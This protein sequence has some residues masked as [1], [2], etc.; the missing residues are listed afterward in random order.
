MLNLDHPPSGRH[1]LQIPVPSP[2]PDRT[3]RALSLPTI[4]HR[5]PEFATL[6]LKV[7]EGLKQAF[8]TRHPVA[9]SP[10]SGTGAWEAA[11][12]NVLSAGDAVLMAETSHFAMLRQK[13]ALRLG[14]APKALDMLLG[15]GLD[16]VLARHRRWAAGVRGAV[17]AWGLP[18]QCV[19]PAA[20]SPVLTGVI[21]PVGVDADAMDFFAAPPKPEATPQSIAAAA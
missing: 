13:M 3:L 8:R 6:G 9:I 15:Q 21:T 19:D 5:G 7:I 2:V 4:D 16:R 17:H 18:V 1:F 20:Q 10:A 14:L 11:L 12:V